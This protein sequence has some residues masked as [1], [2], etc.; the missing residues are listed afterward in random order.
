LPFNRKRMR[1]MPALGSIASEATSLSDV[2]FNAYHEKGTTTVTE[3]WSGWSV[4]LFFPPRGHPRGV[5]RCGLGHRLAPRTTGEKTSIRGQANRNVHTRT[6]P[7][8]FDASPWSTSAIL[9]GLTGR[10]SITSV[11]STPA[12]HRVQHTR[13]Q[14][15][16]S[17][18]K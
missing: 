8:S 13:K 3:T 11:S 17:R 6:S 1:R 16:T 9:A 10:G 14:C 12:R 5:G 18:R 7:D 4:A 2:R 15:R